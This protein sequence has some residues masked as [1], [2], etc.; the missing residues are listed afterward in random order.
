MTKKKTSGD[1]TWGPFYDTYEKNGKDGF[2][3]EQEI[4]SYREVSTPHG[5]YGVPAGSILSFEDKEIIDDG[6]LVTVP[7]AVF[8]QTKASVKNKA[9]VKTDRR[10]EV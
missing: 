1:E 6:E 5:V 7:L 8:K 4:P 2:I 10:V 9:P 3:W